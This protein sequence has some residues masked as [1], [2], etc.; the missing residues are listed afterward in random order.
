[1]LVLLLVIS[2]FWLRLGFEAIN[3]L[4]KFD[5]ITFIFI[6]GSLRTLNNFGDTLFSERKGVGISIVE[7]S[8]CSFDSFG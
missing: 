1:M 5:K 4:S 6:L 3:G 2:Q 8:S 7:P